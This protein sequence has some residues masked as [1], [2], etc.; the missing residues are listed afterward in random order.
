MSFT[1]FK[2]AFL[3]DYGDKLVQVYSEDKKKLF[4]NLMYKDIFNLNKV[5]TRATYDR[6]IASNPRADP[7]CFFNHLKE[8]TI[9]YLSLRE[10]IDMDSTLRITTIQSLGM[11]HHTEL[12]Y[13][14]PYRA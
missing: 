1:D 12:R 3:K 14:P 13:G 4:V 7:H 6:V 9:A 10:V 11:I 8:Y 2:E 5:V